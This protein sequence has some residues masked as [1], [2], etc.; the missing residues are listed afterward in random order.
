MNYWIVSHY[1]FALQSSY[2]TAVSEAE[3]L[4]AKH[5][6]PFHIYRVK[7][8]YEKNDE[9]GTIIPVLSENRE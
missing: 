3:R 5:G 1:D 8:K 6:K 7:Q 2:A 9:T 4:S